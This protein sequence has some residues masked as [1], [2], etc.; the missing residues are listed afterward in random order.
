MQNKVY[1][2]LIVGGVNPAIVELFNRMAGDQFE[3]LVDK[4]LA[5]LTKDGVSMERSMA[6]T[7]FEA[8]LGG[9]AKSTQEVKQ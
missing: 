9:A 3:A 6:D 7:L 1:L 5:K 2:K 8:G 4:S